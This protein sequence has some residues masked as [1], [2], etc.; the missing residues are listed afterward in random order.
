MELQEIDVKIDPDG[1]VHIEVRG[2]KG[3]ACLALTKP[4]EEALGDQVIDRQMTPEALDQPEKKPV[5]DKD[6]DKRRRKA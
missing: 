5:Q 3:P 1:R 6:V 2:V 4:L